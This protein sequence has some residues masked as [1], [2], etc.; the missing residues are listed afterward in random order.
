MET[1][2]VVDDSDVN[3]VMARAALS[4][5]YRV[6]TL[7]SA[8]G[9]FDLLEKILPDLILLDIRMPDIDGF[10]ALE[11]LQRDPRTAGIPVIFLTASTGVS[12]ETRVL[13]AG[14]VDFITKPF[15]KPVLVRRIETH[16][17][18][19]SLIKK[20]TERLERLKNG[21]VSVLADIVEC[22]D[23][24]TGEHIER[25]SKCM[26][27]L[28]NAMSE[29]GLYADEIAGWDIDIAVASARLHD[30]G[31]IAISDVILN[32]PGKL[33][34]EEFD[35]IKRHVKEG[36]QIVDK[37]MEKTGEEEFLIH[38]RAFVSYHHERWDGSGYPYGLSGTDI[39][40]FGRIMAIVDVYDALVSKR[41]YKDPFP[42][43]EAV[44]IIISESGKH[45]DPN[46]TDVFNSVKELF[47]NIYM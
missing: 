18:I 33:T 6:F 37:I 29:Q 43:D 45:F 35:A 9:M 39:P 7:P 25:T 26:R 21:I 46:I 34:P 42:H 16:L 36:E 12:V 32:K 22:R 8:A 47:R 3:L 28:I 41:P 24:N 1:I 17:R 30:V 11:R 27:V 4:D 38:A 10:T 20:R 31:K 44:R 14:A 19:G 5:C 40:L 13:E 15:C 2:F 23:E